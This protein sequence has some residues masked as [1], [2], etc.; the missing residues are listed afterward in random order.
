MACNGLRG[1]ASLAAAGPLPVNLSSHALRAARRQR[2]RVRNES[3]IQELQETVR[4]QAAELQ[5]WRTWWYGYDHDIAERAAIVAHSL[6]IHKQDCVKL[7]HDVH[8]AASA[9]TLVGGDDMAEKLALHRRA[10]LAKHSGF[11]AEG[12]D[13]AVS[14]S[15]NVFDLLSGMSAQTD[16]VI[17]NTGEG[18][19]LFSSGHGRSSSLSD[20][21][22]FSCRLHRGLGEVHVRNVRKT[23]RASR[24]SWRC[25]FCPGR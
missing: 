24:S 11:V 23:S 17:S 15:L 16:S 3:R 14:D 5:S 6:A 4:R 9:A 18:F 21:V 20:P 2:A 7:G 1:G 8:Y 19:C 12:V 10:G 25:R 22:P 13:E